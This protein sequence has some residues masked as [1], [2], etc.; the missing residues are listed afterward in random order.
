MWVFKQNTFHLHG[1]TDVYLQ[2]VNDTNPFM[3][4]GSEPWLRIRSFENPIPIWGAVI[5]ICLCLCF[6]ALFSGLNLGLMSLDRTELK[7]SVLW[8]SI[9][10]YNNFSMFVYPQKDFKKYRH[11]QR[12]SV[13]CQ[14]STRSRSRQFPSLQ[15]FI[16]QCT[17]KFNVYYSTR[18][19]VEWFNCGRVFNNFDCTLRW[20][21]SAGSFINFK[22]CS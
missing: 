19:V 3:H 15:Y 4:Q 17:C 6:S 22:F 2:L 9:N 11:W 7:A 5:I 1:E 8:L 21:Y 18:F 16:G 10:V 13:R 14:N 12:T 20:N